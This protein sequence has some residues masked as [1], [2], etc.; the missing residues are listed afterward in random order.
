MKRNKKVKV[1]KRITILFLVF[2]SSF[3][4]YSDDQIFTA[5]EFFDQV[6]DVYE[7]IEDYEAR[8]SIIQN[9]K[10]MVGGLFYKNPNKIRINFDDPKDQVIV[11]DGS[12]LTIHLPT[13]SV[14]MTQKLVRSSSNAEGLK[15]FKIG[16]SIAYLESPDPVPLDVDSNEYVT[17]L[18][19]G[20]KSTDE[21]FRQI[22]ISVNDKMFIRRIVGITKN[23]EEIVINFENIRINQNIPDARFEYESPA[24]AY[25]INNFIF[26]DE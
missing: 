18:K 12:L 10:E 9:E 23:L 25:V 5:V 2:I 24:S 16:Y 8:V 11:V 15:L 26:P 13:Q 19:L 3:F 14:V 7:S 17:K 20:W 4:L 21:G 1:L 22:E 6:S